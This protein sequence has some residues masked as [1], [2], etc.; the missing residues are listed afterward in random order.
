MKP[1]LFALFLPLFVSAQTD[2]DGL[3][4]GN[5]TVGGI[6]SNEALPMQL[7]LSTDGRFIKGRSYVTLPD[8]EIL[9]MDLKGELYG[10]RSIGMVEIAFVGDSDN[11]VMPEFNRQYQITFKPDL[12]ESELRGFW[13]EV[14]P[15][16]FK[17]T[18]RRGRMVLKK[19]K[20][21]RA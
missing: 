4:E 6:Y 13:Q 15:E 1:L 2:L 16:T 19:A 17:G 3:W 12:W 10:D 20:T 8:G 9:R 18:R 7:Y 21:P 11:D 14:T 5:M